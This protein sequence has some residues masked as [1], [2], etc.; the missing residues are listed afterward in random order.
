MKLGIWTLVLAIVLY[1]SS[2][3]VWIQDAMATSVGGVNLGGGT[4]TNTSLSGGTGVV[5]VNTN[6]NSNTITQLQHQNDTNN[7]NKQGQD[8]STGLG[9]A[10]IAAGM[11]MVAAGMALM[12]NPPTAAAGAALVAAGMMLIAAG[13]AAL[14]AASNMGKNAGQAAQNANYL[15]PT[16]SMLPKTP[17]VA[18]GADLNGA[19]GSSSIRVDPSLAKNPKISQ[20]LDDFEKKTGMSRDDL[21]NGLNSGK[22][23]MEILSASPK[24]GKSEADLQKLMDKSL[25]NNDPLSSQDVMGKLGLTPEDLGAYDAGGD[26]KTAASG[27]AMTDF[28]SLFGKNNLDAAAGGVAL[29]GSVNGS[30]SPELQAA[31]DRNGITSRTIFDMVRTQYKKKMPIMFGVRRTDQGATGN[32]G[33]PIYDLKGTAALEF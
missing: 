16:Q 20:I 29:G 2:S 9:M 13:M 27:S 18:G 11:A 25:A 28:E 17:A 10:A 24:I 31:L 21:M 30:L 7:L 12:A 33:K 14:A 26:R 15:G 5:T 22:G 23:P 3:E 8:S 19:G 6:T 4:S 1:T 32:I